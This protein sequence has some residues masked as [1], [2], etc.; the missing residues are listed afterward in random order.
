MDDKRM[1]KLLEAIINIIFNVIYLPIHV[2]EKTI[3][4]IQDNWRK[5]VEWIRKGIL[6]LWK[7][8]ISKLF[9]PKEIYKKFVI[10]DEVW[11]SLTQMNCNLARDYQE[12]HVFMLVAFLLE[13]V[14]FF[15]T[16]EGNALYFSGLFYEAPLII[17]LVIQLGLLVSA[18]TTFRH[19]KKRYATRLIMVLLLII[20]ILFS[21]TGL[22][23]GN[24]SPKAEYDEAKKD[25]IDAYET[26]LEELKAREP[27]DEK[28]YANAVYIISTTN[29]EVRN[30][31]EVIKVLNERI[32]KTGEPEKNI[33]SVIRETTENGE[34]KSTTVTS[35]DPE[36]IN[37][38][39]MLDTATNE[40]NDLQQFCVDATEVLKKYGAVEDGNTEAEYLELKAYFPLEQE[41][42]TNAELYELKNDLQKLIECNNNL[43]KVLNVGTKLSDEW[44]DDYVDILEWRKRLEDLELEEQGMT[45]EKEQEKQEHYI[46]K[47]LNYLN[48]SLETSSMSELSRQKQEI[49][50]LVNES[51]NRIIA[52][53]GL[54]EKTEERLTE[55]KE[56]VSQLS[57]PL[58]YALDGFC[59]KTTCTTAWICL[60]LA[61]FNDGLAVLFSYAST[62]KAESFLY[63]RTSKDYYTDMDEF[64]QMLFRSMQS[65]YIIKIRKNQFENMSDAE[66]R[67]ECMLQIQNTIDY[68]RQFLN[69]LELSPCTVDDGFDMCCIC[70]NQKEQAKS[71]KEYEAIMSTLAKTNLGKIISRRDYEDLELKFYR[72]WE[73]KGDEKKIY[74]SQDRDEVLTQMR[75]EKERGYV[76][77]LKNRAEN[78]LRGFLS[79]RIVVTEDQDTKKEE[80]E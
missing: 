22:Y 65:N 76:F 48:I 43:C 28:L 54:Q 70:R 42:R 78:Y 17:A 68:I 13:V 35:A 60:F 30:A 41:G 55:A 2:L 79:E 34:P 38:S 62:R 46:D 49:Q 51:Y 53:K 57:D 21:Y 58:E 3:E 37:L 8:W 31:E 74:S 33:V 15:S 10:F 63:I 18:N 7:K 47:I 67:N 66:F 1:Q 24:R 50:S 40:R 59:K 72:D 75:K 26:A 45:E 23:I 56:K 39:N 44:L 64:F 80:E 29:M 27:E 73:F 77:L 20:S 4:W 6:N 19:G 52:T 16:Y 36:Y 71:M 25:Y 14:S 11:R 9:A 69:A 32:E 5:G 12:E 61:L